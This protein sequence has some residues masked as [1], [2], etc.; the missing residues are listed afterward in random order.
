MDIRQ[1]VLDHLST[2]QGRGTPEN[3]AVAAAL[4]CAYMHH[5]LLHLRR[6]LHQRDYDARVYEELSKICLQ[7]EGRVFSIQRLTGQSEL[8]VTGT[9]FRHSIQ[10]RVRNVPGLPPAACAVF[11]SGL[12]DA[13]LRYLLDDL[14]QEV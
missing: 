12:A 10:E 13:V 4:I 5:E 6:E 11:A 7:V 2:L 8:V 3:R 14:A 1:E 9:G